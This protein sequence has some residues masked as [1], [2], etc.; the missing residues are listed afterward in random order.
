MLRAPLTIVP[1]AKNRKLY[2]DR[3]TNL[4]TEEANIIEIDSGFSHL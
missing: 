2:I 3:L 4:M 1:L